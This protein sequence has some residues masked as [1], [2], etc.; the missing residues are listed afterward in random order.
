M[1]EQMECGTDRTDRRSVALIALTD[2]R[3]RDLE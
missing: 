3:A 1:I 2:A